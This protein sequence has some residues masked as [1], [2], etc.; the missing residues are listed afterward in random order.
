ML[1]G[2]FKRCGCLCF[3]SAAVM[4][5]SRRR[6]QRPSIRSHPAVCPSARLPAYSPLARASKELALAAART[7]NSTAFADRPRAN[8]LSAAPA[9]AR[10]DGL[11]LRRLMS[12]ECRRVTMMTCQGV[13]MIT[14]HGMKIMGRDGMNARRPPASG[15]YIRLSPLSLL[16]HAKR[17]P[18]DGY[19]DLPQ[20][21]YLARCI[22]WASKC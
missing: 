2:G 6:R 16:V 7:R 15:A 4:C 22:D 10:I 18:G 13:D 12:G 17:M 19:G 9:D 1:I 11:C 5:L 21:G 14:C 3:Q 8:R 20:D